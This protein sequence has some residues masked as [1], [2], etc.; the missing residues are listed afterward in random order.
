MTSICLSFCWISDEP[1][2]IPCLLHTQS[3]VPWM[4]LHGIRI[5]HPTTRTLEVSVCITQANALTHHVH[6]L[7]DARWFPLSSV[8]FGARRRLDSYVQGAACEQAA[9]PK[10]AFHAQ[11]LQGL[12]FKTWASQFVQ[13]YTFL[14]P[15]RDYVLKWLKS[16]FLCMSLIWA[17]KWMEET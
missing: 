10:R 12:L 5:S 6:R 8:N 17:W 13:G 14:R 2:H 4:Q 11:A 1:S 16:D 9:K 3:W 7:M 15:G